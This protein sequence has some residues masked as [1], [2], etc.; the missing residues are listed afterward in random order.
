M[1]CYVIVYKSDTL[2]TAP[3]KT[4]PIDGLKTV[5]SVDMIIV[6]MMML[7]RGPTHIST[8][9]H[10]RTIINLL[11]DPTN[12]QITLT[13]STSDLIFVT[14]VHYHFFYITLHV[15][16]C[17]QVERIDDVVQKICRQIRGLNFSAVS[18]NDKKECKK[19]NLIKEE[20]VLLL[21]DL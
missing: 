6:L 2:T 21:H 5:W 12:T 13:H 19:R 14:L 8:T 20:L 17:C 3:P 16:N 18:D 1:L 11:I 15:G 7:Y 4:K 10:T 9:K